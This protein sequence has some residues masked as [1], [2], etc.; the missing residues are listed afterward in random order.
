MTKPEEPSDDEPSTEE[1]AQMKSA[2]PKEA[3]AVDAMILSRCSPRWQKVANVVGQLLD[4]F[5]EKFAHLPFAYIQARMQDLEDQGELEIMGD[6]WSIRH[7]EVRL[8][9][10]LNEL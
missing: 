1:I 5:E 4:E 2:T 9:E 10:R 6:V 3:G 7:S 8:V